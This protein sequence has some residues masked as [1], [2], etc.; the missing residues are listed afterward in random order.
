MPTTAQFY[1][2]TEASGIWGK[3]RTTVHKLIQAGKIKAFRVGSMW[4]ISAATVRKYSKRWPFSE[5][6]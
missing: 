2:I 3:H 6:A 4:V 5:P 1:N